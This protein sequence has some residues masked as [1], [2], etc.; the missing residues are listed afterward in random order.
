[1]GKLIGGGGLIAIALFMLLG[2]ANASGNMSALVAGIT[3]LIIV[4]APAIGGAALLR[5]HFQEQ[6]RLQ[7]QKSGLR[8]RTIEAEIVK[9]AESKG[10]KLTVSEVV[11]GLAMDLDEAKTALDSL[12]QNSVADIELT[13]DGM[14]VY[15]FFEA[16]HL[17]G[18]ST[19]RG[20]LDD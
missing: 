3:F 19:S 7:R 9:L 16:K 6:S 12:H 18:K 10:G 15:T 5:S 8:D 20:V 14:M 17:P 2:F 4:V 1:M 13:E 11:S